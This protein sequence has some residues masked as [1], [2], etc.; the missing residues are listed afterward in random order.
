MTPAAV[1]VPVST[2]NRSAPRALIDEIMVSPKRSAS[3][4]PGPRWCRRGSRGAR[5]PNRAPN[6]VRRGPG[7]G[8]A[9]SAVRPAV[10]SLAS[11]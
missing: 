10:R 5:P 11:L 3:L 6:S 4:R 7:T 1:N 2:E 8:L 9:R